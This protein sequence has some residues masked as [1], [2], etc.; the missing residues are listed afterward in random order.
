V[1]G[2]AD[3]LQ[4]VAANLLQNALTAMP[5]GGSLTVGLA[6][7]EGDAVCLSV[8]DTGKGIPESLRERVFDPFFTTKDEPGRVGLGL[9]VAHRIIEAHHGRIRLESTEGQGTTVTIILPAAGAEA[10]LT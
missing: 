6:A 9:S 8:K 10:H 4:K 5:K 1:L 2:H 3:Q 7:V